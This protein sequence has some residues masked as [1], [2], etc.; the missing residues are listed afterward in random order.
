MQLEII[1]ASGGKPC[2]E[3]MKLEMATAE[4]VGRAKIMY[5]CRKSFLNAVL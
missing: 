3:E 2:C 5:H 1:G 4:G